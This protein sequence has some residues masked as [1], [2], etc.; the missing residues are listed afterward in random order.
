MAFACTASPPEGNFVSS[1]LS[2][3]DCQAQSIGEGGYQ[4][5]AS[6]GSAVVLMLGGLLSI[7]IALF[8]YRMILGR[9]PDLSDSVTAIV[10][11]GIVLTLATSW[12]AYR[13]LIYDV[14]MHG[15]AELASQIGADAGLP[16]SEGGLVWQLQRA[17]NGLIELGKLGVG[18]RQLQVGPTAEPQQ[19]QGAAQRRNGQQPTVSAS[20][21]IDR[22]FDLEADANALRLARTSFLV[23]TLGVF[24][25]VRLFAGLLLALGPL[26]AL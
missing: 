13:T 7:F 19:G 16:G 23:G 20:Q 14:T 9:M 3:V 12:S 22:S 1:V 25:L 18:R 10:K 11:I 26:F 5:L 15:P 2:Y 17:D 4:A 24:A 6:P 8:G 21:T